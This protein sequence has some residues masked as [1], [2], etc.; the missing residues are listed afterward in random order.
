[1]RS[2][3]RLIPYV[4]AAVGLLSPSL[5]P[6][7]ADPSAS[8]AP[9]SDL[10]LLE[11]L[12]HEADEE[13]WPARPE[14]QDAFLSWLDRADRV[15]ARRVEH[16]RALAE[17]RERARP[18]GEEARRRDRE[19][20]PLRERLAELRQPRF[21][22]EGLSFVRRD[23][24]S[25]EV[26]EEI[27][28]LERA[29]DERRTWEFDS[30]DDRWCHEVRTEILREYAALGTPGS[31]AIDDVR[32]RASRAR[33]LAALLVP[34][35]R[36]LRDAGVDVPALPGYRFIGRDPDSGLIE[37]AHLGS[38]LVPERD[39]EG[40][41]RIA[42]ETGLV[43]VRLEG[44]VATVGAVPPGPER[45]LGEPH[46]DPHATPWESPIHSVK[47]EPFLISK[48]ELT[49]GQW[50][51]LTGARPSKYGPEVQYED[52]RHDLTH[53]V[54]QVSWY[55]CVRAL[56]R[57]GMELPTEVQWEYAARAG[58]TTPW[59]TGEE[60][61]SIAGYMN[62]AD[63]TAARTGMIWGEIQ[64][65][66][67]LVDGYVVHAPA[68]TYRANPYG[69]HNMYGNVWEWCRDEFG[70]YELP[71]R[72]GDG[73]RRVYGATF[74]AVRGGAC[75]MTVIAS[76]SANRGEDPPEIRSHLIGVRPVAP[77]RP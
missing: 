51:R 31:G 37:F 39:A 35:R 66:P 2:S 46:V 21:V 18:Y 40:R 75:N 41:L 45:H 36:R 3:V 1:M 72:D 28:R 48:Y 9:L 52:V 32:R 4:V 60:K 25:D 56:R 49:Q 20:H 5:W 65:W 23:D 61:E 73:L 33:E 43:F 12:R 44:G 58:T 62:I 76:R 30:A 15:M 6:R 71:A 69:L 67:E 53:P 19:E 27:A 77:L 17:L 7:Q 55:E 74:R 42:D 64:H 13:L 11:E 29:L 50:E 24:P 14:R 54:E 57:W 8:A 59:V 70:S 38:G 63:Q 34:E 10:A 68:G 47:L 16:E 26:R 22:R